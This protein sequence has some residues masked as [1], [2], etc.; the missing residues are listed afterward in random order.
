M[1]SKEPETGTP[2]PKRPERRAHR[3]LPVDAAASLYL[4]DLGA[5]LQ[6]RILNLGASGCRI[7]LERRFPTGIYRRAEIEFSL[8]GFPFRLAGVT[9]GIYG[10]HDVGVRFVNLSTRKRDQLMQAIGEIAAASSPE[11]QKTPAV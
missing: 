11:D 10:K 6:G 3:R 4:V 1:Q 9:Q 2:A 5:R 7:Q 8:N